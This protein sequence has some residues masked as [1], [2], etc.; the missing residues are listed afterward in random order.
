MS[1]QSFNQT[2]GNFVAVTTAGEEVREFVDNV[3]SSWAWTIVQAIGGVSAVF[4]V[5]WLF[6]YYNLAWPQVI[7]FFVGVVA[8]LVFGLGVKTN[9]AIATV[10]VAA[11][12][13]GAGNNITV[14]NW[15]TKG[16]P[17]TLMIYMMV[18]GLL[19]IWPWSVTLKL[20]MIGYGAA[21]LVYVAMYNYGIPDKL[22]K[23]VI[24][25]LGTLVIIMVGY[26]SYAGG[27]YVGNIGNVW[28]AEAAA[29][30]AKE[31]A[32]KQA[33]YQGNQAAYA[34]QAQAP[35]VAPEPVLLGTDAF[36]TRTAGKFAPIIIKSGTRVGP[37]NMYAACN[38][39]WDKSGMGMIS[40]LT[41]PDFK[42]EPVKAELNDDDY[43]IKKVGHDG[44]PAQMFFEAVQG[45]IQIEMFRFDNGTNTDNPCK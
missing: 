20:Y 26:Q 27:D 38:L 11:R 45:D 18:S 21:L 15:I 19:I 2:N 39:S 41:R 17:V 10:G 35:V 24:I 4:Y 12:A 30:K 29:E 40:I 3:D 6:D 5:L 43:S 25:I 37:I 42:S 7:S 1:R 32:A 14:R 13:I 28:R 22:T 31:D 8:I 23:Y 33:A 9:M 34:P 36:T 44:K 16:L